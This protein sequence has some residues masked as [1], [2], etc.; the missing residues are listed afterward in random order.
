MKNLKKLSAV[1]L[2]LVMALAMTITA[3]ADETSYKYEAYQIFSGTVDNGELTGLA[4]GNGVDSAALVAGL[5]AHSVIGA[6]FAAAATATDVAAVLDGYTDNSA[7][8]I[9]FAEV[10]AAH[11]AAAGKVNGTSTVNLPAAG[12]YLIKDAADADLSG[13]SYT[14]YI[15]KTSVAGEVTLVRKAS[16]PSMIKKVKENTTITSGTV[17]VKGYTTPVDY[18]D[19]ADYNIGDAVP[20]QIVGTLPENFSDYGKYFYQFTDRYDANEFALV[21]G[22][23]TVKVN[24][25]TDVTS[26]FTTAATTEP[27]GFTVT[28]DDLTAISNLTK[29][30]VIVVDYQLTLLATCKVGAGNG[31]ENVAKLTFS[32]NPN[33]DEDGNP[34]DD[35]EKDR[36]E[37]PEDK[38]VVFTYTV[39][40]EKIDG[41]TKEKLANVEFVFK[42]AAGKFVTVDE[43]GVVTG[44]VDAEE[45]ASVLKT[46]ENGAFA[47]I[48]LDDATYSLVET[49]ALPGYNAIDPVEVIVDADT[50]NTQE[51]DGS[52]ASISTKV[53]LK[54]SG[55][56][57]TDGKV[58]VENNSGATLPTTGGI[59]TTIF[60]VVGAV[61]VIAAGVL[62]ITKRRMAK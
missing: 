48:G 23:I 9:A 30:D 13:D 3:W 4:W 22:S 11:V 44:W 50:K 12:Y 8:M 52:Q 41:T 29:N 37:T 38:V 59:G 42:N 18:N 20:F 28:C 53:D 58:V 25:T 27:N 26:S 19:S 61:L 49:K 35:K 6:D 2:A 56:L 45:D 33:R 46:D 39:P 32:N 57:C 40:V 54:A 7:E 31:N 51:W 16:V 5:K 21:D 24:G 36:A 43:D 14:R 62:L 34:S 15:V 55:I 60:Y 47:I 17:S 1:L 10:V